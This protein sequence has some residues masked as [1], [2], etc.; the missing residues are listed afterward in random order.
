MDK[1][2]IEDLCARLRHVAK[3]YPNVNLSECIIIGNYE[4]L[5]ENGYISNVRYVYSATIDDFRLVNTTNYK[6]CRDFENGFK[7]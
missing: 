1:I 5:T 2:I 3:T 4:N 6:A 7:E